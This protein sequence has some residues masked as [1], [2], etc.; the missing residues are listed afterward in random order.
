MTGVGS[1]LG[2]PGRTDRMIDRW[3]RHLWFDPG[4]GTA[5]AGLHGLG[6]AMG[7]LVQPV[8]LS[9]AG[10]RGL[11]IDVAG[12]IGGVV[13]AVAFSSLLFYFGTEGRLTRR[14][15]VS[16]ADLVQRTWVGG[17]R[18]PLECVGLLVVVAAMAE[19]REVAGL[20]V[21]AWVCEAAVLT[22]FFR[23]GRVVWL[24]AN[25]LSL[26][27]RELR[28]PPATVPGQV[29]RREREPAA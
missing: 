23:A 21:L 13:V 15:S 26:R 14:L 25:V 24:F 27:N 20:G 18:Q 12:V 29:R 16:H 11:V 2:T 4:A 3:S 5:V 19:S 7:W 17:F 22:T 9:A 1:Y 10:A 8:D 6:V 28:E